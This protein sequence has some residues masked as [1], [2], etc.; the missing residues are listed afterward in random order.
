M[1]PWLSSVPLN[2]GLMEGS[3]SVNVHEVVTTTAP[4]NTWR[5]GIKSIHQQRHPADESQVTLQEPA[6]YR[7]TCCK[8]D[9]LSR[10]AKIYTHLRSQSGEHTEKLA[11]RQIR[12]AFLSLQERLS[13][14]TEHISP[15]AFENDGQLGVERLAHGRRVAVTAWWGKRGET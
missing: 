15:A 3:I 13:S 5:A 7:K 14:S 12:M 4:S 9:C 11:G 6:S 2:I 8:T 1:R 10:T